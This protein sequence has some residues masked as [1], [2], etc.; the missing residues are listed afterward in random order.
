MN[1]FLLII[2]DGA[3]FP[4]ELSSSK[5]VYRNEILFTWTLR[6][7]TEQKKIDQAKTFFV[8]NMVCNYLCLSI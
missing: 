5:M 8:A 3:A 2:Q 6:D 4:I 7:I 1:H